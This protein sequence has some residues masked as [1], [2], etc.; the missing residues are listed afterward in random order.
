MVPGTKGSKLIKSYNYII[1]NNLEKLDKNFFP[2]GQ[3]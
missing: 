2:F 3:L 1:F